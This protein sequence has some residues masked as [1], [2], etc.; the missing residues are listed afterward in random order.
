MAK[1]HDTSLLTLLRSLPPDKKA[2][3][4]NLLRRKCQTDLWFFLTQILFPRR[5]FSEK[6]HRPMCELFVKKNPN[7]LI[8]TEHPDN[9]DKLDPVK[10]RLLLAPRNSFKTTIDVADIIQWIITY[11]NLA[12]L[13]LSGAENLA[14]K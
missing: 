14:I 11:P 6:V 3:Q 9:L 8:D 10:Q 2:E 5:K 13:I 4:I 1:A 7:L 12:I